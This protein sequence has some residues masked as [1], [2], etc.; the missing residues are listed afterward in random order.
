MYEPLKIASE[1]LE[2][3]KEILVEEKNKDEDCISLYDIAQLMKKTNNDY[4][5]IKG[6]YE[7][8]CDEIIK[9][10]LGSYDS[11]VIYDFDYDEKRLCIGVKIWPDDY[12]DITFAKSEDDLYIS[13]SESSWDKEVFAYLSA[14]LVNL[15]DELIKFLSFKKE[16]RYKLKTVNSNFFVSIGSFGVDILAKSSTNQ[17][18]HDFKLSFNSYTNDYKCYCNSST[19]LNAFRGK[20]E[21]IFQRI[22]VKISDCPKWSQSTL[23]E[24]RQN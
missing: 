3:V 8:R 4:E 24:I 16:K 11:L 5:R 10:K 7:S 2:D 23:Y 14:E 1:I 9:S 17:F 6:I 21:E 13:K 19:V 22:F 12:K 18:D 15:Y 20:E